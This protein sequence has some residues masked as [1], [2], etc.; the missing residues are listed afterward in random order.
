MLTCADNPTEHVPEAILPADSEQVLAHVNNKRTMHGNP[1]SRLPSEG[2]ECS[3]HREGS[4]TSRHCMTQYEGSTGQAQSQ[5]ELYGE[6]A[7]QNDGHTVTTPG[8][9]IKHLTQEPVGLRVIAEGI[10]QQ[11]GDCYQLLS[12]NGIDKT[13]G[14]YVDQLGKQINPVD[15]SLQHT[16]EQNQ[17]L[18]NMEINEVSSDDKSSDGDSDSSL[19]NESDKGLGKPYSPSFKELENA[20]PPELGMIFPTLEDAQRFY[21]IHAL[22]TGFVVKRGTNYKRKKFTLECHKTGKSKLT[23]NPKRKRKRNIIERTQC[24]AKVIVKF[25]K[26]QWEFA[27]VRNEHNHPLCPSYSLSRFLKRKRRQNRPNKKQLHVQR[28]SELL[29]QAYNLKGQ[30]LQPLISANSDEVAQVNNK[31]MSEHS[32]NSLTTAEQEYSH[33]KGSETRNQLDT[34]AEGSPGRILHQLVLHGEKDESSNGID[35]TAEQPI[36][37]QLGEQNS[38]MGQSLQHT[39]EQ[40]RSHDSMESNEVPSDDTSSES[41]SDSSSGDELDKELGKYF[42]PSFE[43]LENSRPPELGMKFPSLQAAHRFYNAHAFLTGFAGKRGTNY[44]RKKFHI[45][46]NRSGKSKSA[47]N[48]KKK[49]KSNAIEKTRCQAR[50]IVKLN[51]G[52]WEFTSVRNEHNHRLCPSPSLTRFFLNHKQMS[53]EEKSFLRVLQQS[54]IPPKKVLKIFRKMKV[55]FKNELFENKDENNILQT[56]QRRANSDVESTLNHFME[57]QLRNPGFLYTMPKDEDNIVRSVFWTDAK[58]RMDYEFFGDIILFDTTYSTD[59]HNMPFVPIIGINN[60]ARPLVLGCA[61]LKDEEAETFKWMLHTFLEVMERKMPRAVIIDQDSSM[62]KAI[63]EVMP[64]VRLRFCKQHVM[65]NAQE[66]I[67]AFMAA[68]GNINA[69][70]HNLVDNSLIETEFEEGWAELIGRYNA[71]ENQH[72]QFMWQTRKSWVPVYFRE[73]FYPFISNNGTYSLFKDNMLPKDTIDRFIEQYEEIQEKITKMGDEDRFQSGA[74]LKYISMQP[75]EQHAAH[76]Y[77]RQIFLKVQKELLH[78]TAFNVQEI[79]RGTV[80]R[81]EK[82]FSYENPEFDRNY[83]EVLIEPGI[84]AFKCQCAKFKRDGIPCCHIFRLFT[85]FGINEIPEQYKVPRWTK[86]F[87][88]D[89]IKQYKE[90]FL[91][92]HGINDSENTLRYAMVM[93]KAAEIGQEICHDEAKC[94]RFMLELGKI[95]EKLITER[96]ENPV[97]NGETCCE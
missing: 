58:S 6:K 10:L 63:A 29:T 50:V 4:W 36:V 54:R 95:Q 82:V 57:L 80:Y 23:P 13:A 67:G 9:L 76:I 46:C 24:Q 48:P 65:R 86:N 20:R 18:D 49:R 16:E 77:T 3:H 61:L 27:A 7:S 94:S 34:Q 32:E 17:S 70:L 25:N 11:I 42:Y 79:E 52:E 68:G 81:L 45:E 91:D 41:D 15:Q 90:K 5:P 39:E 37:D 64:H 8:D 40:S 47:E 56:K 85:Q 44:K 28:N 66:K 75:I 92:K 43:E 19:G 30:V 96:G 51:K 55:C 33:R 74:D 72:L 93:S 35:R 84:N 2:K 21:D 78:S 62:E 14:L 53:T 22:K 12:S 69:D 89:Q 31:R 38:S 1:E 88:E 73:D 26:G 87:R 60:H 71:S 97:N 59:R 83:F